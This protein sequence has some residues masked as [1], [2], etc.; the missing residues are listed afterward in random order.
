MSSYSSRKKPGYVL[1]VWAI[2]LAIADISCQKMRTANIAFEAMLTEDKE[3]LSSDSNASE[4]VP[5][6]GTALSLTTPYESE[7]MV[8]L[9][10]GAKRFYHL[11]EDCEDASRIIQAT[12]KEAEKLG[13]KLCPKCKERQNDLEATGE[14]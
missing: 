2:F 10:I 13:Y 1:V 7:E 6:A 3:T 5:P 8:S 4:S 14:E 12:Q 9:S 11:S